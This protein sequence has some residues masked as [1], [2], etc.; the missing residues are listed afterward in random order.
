MLSSLSHSDSMDMCGISL[1]DEAVVAT[2]PRAQVQG[3]HPPFD[4]RR[5]R[6][7]ECRGI[8]A[9]RFTENGSVFCLEHG[10]FCL[11]HTSTRAEDA[12]PVKFHTFS[13]ELHSMEHQSAMYLEKGDDQAGLVSAAEVDNDILS[14][15]PA[16]TAEGTTSDHPSDVAQ[17]GGADITTRRDS[18]SSPCTGDNPG[19]LLRR[20]RTI[21][22]WINHPDI[23]MCCQD[24]ENAGDYTITL[25]HPTEFIPGQRWRFPEGTSWTYR[26]HK[27][28]TRR[29]PAWTVCERGSGRPSGLS[30]SWVN[31]QEH[32]DRT[33]MPS[34]TSP[35]ELTLICYYV[36]GEPN[37]ADSIPLGGGMER[38]DTA[39]APSGSGRVDQ[40]GG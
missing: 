20:H 32:T 7:S 37:F 4:C 11:S 6:Y 26:N 17:M 39:S 18:H 40:L 33:Y 19:R 14:G 16:E 3:D 24:G 28:I 12:F 25:L 35:R 23:A 36:D 15:I 38:R 21:N 1:S 13:P 9:L 27:W 31:G 29:V 34:Q 8:V 2:S 10:V 5:L 22:T 30:E